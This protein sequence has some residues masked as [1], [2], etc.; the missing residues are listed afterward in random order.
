VTDVSERKVDTV[1]EVLVSR[2]NGTYRAQIE[3]R[4]ADGAPL[5]SRSVE[6]TAS[7][8]GSLASAA[9]LSIALLFEPFAKRA[10]PIEKPKAAPSPQPR[11]APRARDQE[12]PPVKETPGPSVNASVLAVGATAV[13]PRTAAGVLLAGGVAFSPAWAARARLGILLEQ[14]VSRASADVGFSAAI[15]TVGACYRPVGSAHFGLEACAG[16]ALTALS[17]AV[18]APVPV[19]PGERWI[20]GANAGLR[21][22]ARHAWLEFEAGLDALAPFARREFQVAHAQSTPGAVFTQPPLG[23]LATLGLGARY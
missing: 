22:S 11:P 4:G 14:R 5:G 13:L 6:S 16:I 17:V 2:D 8:C 7:N 23:V 15:G 20:A 18:Y 1:V 10:A 21:L 19:A 12:A 9:A 3:M